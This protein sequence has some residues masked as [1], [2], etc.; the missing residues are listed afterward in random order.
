MS[1]TS[2]LFVAVTEG[3]IG[4]GHQAPPPLRVLAG[5]ATDA[6]S[7][8]IR[9]GLFAVACWRIGDVRFHFDSSF[10][11]PEARTEFQALARL[12]KDRTDTRSASDGKPRPPPLSIFGHADPTGSDLYNKALSG[13]RAAAIYAVLTRKTEIWEDLFSNS[14]K[15]AQPAV[16]D[17]WNPEAIRA[18]RAALDLPIDGKTT[19]TERQ[20]LFSAYMDFLCIDEQQKPFQVDPKEGFLGSQA[21]SLGKGDYQGCSEFNPILLFSRV[22]KQK[23]DQQKDHTERDAANAPNRRVVVL[24]FRPGSRITPNLWPCPRASESAAGC[25]KRFFSDG[26]KRR[27]NEGQQREFKDKED[28]FA[29]RF[30]QR[31]ATRCPCERGDKPPLIVARFDTQ[32]EAR[33]KTVQ[34]VVFDGAD[35]EV[36]TIPGEKATDTS[37]GFFVFRFNPSELPDPV[38]L[39]WRT[40]DGEFHLAGPC[41]PAQL[42]DA[43]AGLDLEQGH[44]L[45]RDPATERNPPS[46]PTPPSDDFLVNIITESADGDS[47][48]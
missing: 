7:N 30:Y 29:C 28:T 19:R 20:A 26:D 37:E 21:D 31:L 17:Q 9:I 42:R 24:L 47:A 6:Q 38:R 12:I 8:L 40:A 45:V 15:F 10:V 16:G 36:R 18:M 25:R 11:V 35:N 43:L 27:S 33:D 32:S 46:P 13:R 5:P 34:L 22:D 39:E 3:G 14:G 48:A 44:S 4:A 23:F 41:S 2:E 1:D